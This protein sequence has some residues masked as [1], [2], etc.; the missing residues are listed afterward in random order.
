M[1][2]MKSSARKPRKKLGKKV[3]N[4]EK[5]KLKESSMDSREIILDFEIVNHH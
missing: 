2:L 5:H 4:S 3:V 1:Q